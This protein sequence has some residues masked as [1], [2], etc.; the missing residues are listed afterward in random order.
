MEWKKELLSAVL[1]L[2]IAFVLGVIFDLLFYH[3]PLANVQNNLM[4][5]VALDI[6]L[7]LFDVLR[8]FIMRHHENKMKRRR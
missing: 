2:G 6:V 4:W 5:G 3:D 7:F 8:Y 1:V